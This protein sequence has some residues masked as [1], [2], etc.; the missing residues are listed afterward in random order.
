MPSWA[1]IACVISYTTYIIFDYTDGKQARRLKASSPLGL[2]V[3]HGT[4]ACTTFYVTIVSG[5]I[6]YLTEMRQYLFFYIPLTAA[7]FMNT[8]EEYY[9]G[10]LVLPEINGV[11]EGTLYADIVYILSALYGREF[12]LK[13]V[14]IF[15]NYK[16]RINDLDTYAI[17][18]M[19]C[20]FS[21]KSLFGVLKKVK[22]DKIYDAIRT[23][24][25]YPLFLSTILSVTFLSDSI[26]VKKY[27]KFLILTFG[28]LFSKIMGILQ[29]SHILGSPYRVYQPVFLI[30]IFSLLIHS[31]VYYFYNCS[32]LVSIDA[33]I[34]S[35]FI[36]NFISWAHFVYFCSEEICETLN[37]KRFTLGKR[38]P[39]R[40]SYEEIKNKLC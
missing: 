27:P 34:I 26:I 30:P 18:G 8:W 2:L 17:F 25:M 16:V 28:F 20:F 5:S 10:E 7:F 39:S 38:Y 11:A 36:W 23:S 32:L 9:M 31:L 4:D 12:Y 35:V 21:L 3:D 19:G 33:L 37:I 13:E 22:K 24:L 15:G 6:T 29:L 40:P 1:I 14:N